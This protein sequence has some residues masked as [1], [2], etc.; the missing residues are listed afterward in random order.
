MPDYQLRLGIFSKSYSDLIDNETEFITYLMHSLNGILI[1]NFPTSSWIRYMTL[2][3][4]MRVSTSIMK[5][6]QSS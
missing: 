6:S 5:L 4:S 2:R 3:K 1:S